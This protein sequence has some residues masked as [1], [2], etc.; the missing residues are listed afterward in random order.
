MAT[1]NIPDAYADEQFDFVMPAN[2]RDHPAV[3]AFAELLQQDDVQRRL[4]ELTGRDSA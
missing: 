4:S 1:V 3:R 2:R